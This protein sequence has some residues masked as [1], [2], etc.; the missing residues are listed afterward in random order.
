MNFI[1]KPIITALLGIGK[2]MLTAEIVEYA[3]ILLLDEAV[4]RSK[5]KADDKLLAKVKEQLGH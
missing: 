5:S 4:K 1:L 3:V 2:K